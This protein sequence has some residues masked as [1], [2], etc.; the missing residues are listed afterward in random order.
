MTQS[1][2][3]TIETFHCLRLIRL[4]LLYFQVLFSSPFSSIGVFHFFSVPVSLDFLRGFLSWISL[5]VFLY[6]RSICTHSLYPLFLR[7]G[8]FQACNWLWSQR[9]R[10]GA[11]GTEIS[12][13]MSA[14]VEFS[15]VPRSKPFLP[16][17][18]QIHSAAIFEFINFKVIFR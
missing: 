4:Y 5:V 7:L 6:D 11:H 3:L 18:E 10:R 8:E 2:N 15:A 12:I 9:R 17:R 1:K 16:M 14:L 13:K